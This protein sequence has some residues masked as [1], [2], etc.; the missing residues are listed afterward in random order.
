MNVTLFYSPIVAPSVDGQRGTAVLSTLSDSNRPLFRAWSRLTPPSQPV[1]NCFVDDGRILVNAELRAASGIFAAGSVAK[2]PN[3]A[4]GHAS[5]AGEG[6]LAGSAAGEVA[7]QNMIKDYCE[8]TAGASAKLRK[9]KEQVNTNLSFPSWRTDV[10]PLRSAKSDP[11]MLTTTSYLSSIGVHAICIGQCD[12][13]TMATH[14]FWWTNQALNRRTAILSQSSDKHGE[15]REAAVEPRWS[16]KRGLSVRR[17]VYG[18]GVVYY[19]DRAGTIRGVMMWGFP[20]AKRDGS[21]PR[22]ELLKRMQNV[23]RTN[24]RVCVLKHAEAVEEQTGNAHYQD[25]LTCA[26]LSEESKLLALMSFNRE[27]VSG[28]KSEERRNIFSRPLHRYTPSKPESVTSIGALQ[29]NAT[30]T[31]TGGVGEDMFIKKS[32]DDKERPQSLVYVYPLDSSS[33]VEFGY[34]EKSSGVVVNLEDDVKTSHYPSITHVDNL[35]WSRPSKEE[36]L[37]LRKGDAGRAI[38]RNDVM[39]D[40]FF[41]NI[42]HGR[43]YDGSEAIKQAPQ[44]K[45]ASGAS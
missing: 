16:T 33:Q 4:T 26:H 20:F 28:E 22:K 2:F 43:F 39:A 32:F 18:S 44:S 27:P 21:T 42:R 40:V 23:I 3:S 25:L 5:V 17:A 11:Q 10:S 15:Q 41:Q 35:K 31:G 30:Y 24:G 8:R 34:G 38:S 6:V 1:L 45:S 37:W 36:P 14:G 19:L 9:G 13:E 7:A 12:S 29:R